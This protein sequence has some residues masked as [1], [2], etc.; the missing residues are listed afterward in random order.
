MIDCLSHATLIAGNCWLLAAISSLT[1]YQDLMD[2]V[3]P[4][5]QGFSAKEGYCG[6]FRFKFWVFGKWKEIIIDDYLP[7]TKGRLVF[8]HS[9]DN[10]EFWAALMEKAYAK[11]VFQLASSISTPER[12]RHV[13]SSKKR[14]FSSR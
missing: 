10:N 9:P 6:M 8:M 14:S 2:Q 5:D 1:L 13:R 7:T 4:K 11:Y 12:Q 3:I